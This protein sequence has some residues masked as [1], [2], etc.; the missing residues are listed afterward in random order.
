[1][2]ANKLLKKKAIGD[3]RFT[4]AECIGVPVQEKLRVVQLFSH[5]IDISYPPSAKEYSQQP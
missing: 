2:Y 4:L 5:L 1:M 3:N